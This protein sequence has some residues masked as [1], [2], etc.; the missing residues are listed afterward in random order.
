MCQP[1]KAT[2][3]VVPASSVPSPEHASRGLQA[4]S[5]H[6]KAL[7]DVYVAFMPKFKES[8]E[9]KTTR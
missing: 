8:K 3:A 4:T 9:R 6:P 7:H 2:L 1:L 5:M